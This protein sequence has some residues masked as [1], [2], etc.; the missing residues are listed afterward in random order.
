MCEISIS[1]R[2][3]SVLQPGESGVILLADAPADEFEDDDILNSLNGPPSPCDVHF[4]NDNVLIDGKSSISKHPKRHKVNEKNRAKQ[5]VART[6]P[7]GVDTLPPFPAEKGKKTAAPYAT[8]A[9]FHA[10]SSD[11]SVS[12]ESRCFPVKVVNVKLF[13]RC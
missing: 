8:P 10:Y 5:P 6:Y 1:E 2:A 11:L 13:R 3:F 9:T 4:E 7:E 12:C